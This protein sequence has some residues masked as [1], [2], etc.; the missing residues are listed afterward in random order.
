MPP[1]RYPTGAAEPIATLHGSEAHPK[2]ATAF[3]ARAQH[4]VDLA[5]Y[6]S[7]LAVVLAA[8]ALATVTRLTGLRRG[9]PA[10]GPNQASPASDTLDA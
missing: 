4:H 7:G 3:P 8:S 10:T 9:T 5:N 6:R 2:R 1:V